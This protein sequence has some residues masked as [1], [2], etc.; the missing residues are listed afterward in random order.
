[1][2]VSIHQPQY[3]PW[4]PYF[5]KI[6]KSDIFIVYDTV[7][8]PR[9]KGLS[10]RNFIR[11]PDGN[12]VLLTVPVSKR[13][14]KLPY[15]SIPVTDSKW[16]AKHFRSI[17]NSYSK[18]KYFKDYSFDV[19]HIYLNNSYSYLCEVNIAF[20][21]YIIHKLNF[22]TK[23]IKASELNISKDLFTTENYILEILNHFNA[24]LYLTGWGEG[25]RRY[26]NPNSFSKHNIELK[27]YLFNNPSYEQYK[28]GFIEDL[29]VLDVLFNCG[30]ETRAMLEKNG[31]I[32]DI[33]TIK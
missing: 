10:N 17:E 2:I 29:S 11:T 23:I 8:Y 18:S 31:E 16:A 33:L 24:S 28:S 12:K 14:D 32:V 3:I 20:I 15:Y 6:L 7:Q 1:M 4:L 25:S 27:T 26:I 9:S 22:R 19:E 21:E 13:G 5:Y 30:D